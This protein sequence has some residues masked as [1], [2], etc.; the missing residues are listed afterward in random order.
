MTAQ[1]RAK[2]ERV[3]EAVRRG[4]DGEGAIGFIRESGYATTAAGIARHLRSM[5][6]RGKVLEFI[7]QGLSNAQVLL[8]CFPDAD[9]SA[10]PKEPPSQGELFGF[11]RS[12]V[13]LVD[14]D[15]ADSPVY[16]TTKISVRL[17]ND[18]C[19]AIRLAAKAEGTT[20]SQ[21]ITEILTTAL[22]RSPEMFPR[23][24]ESA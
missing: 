18:L 12:T 16:D 23:E 24:P 17:P 13:R 6:G 22:S 3:I 4:L 21:L 19:E 1:L 8:R 7:E 20:Q 2:Q 9:L 11:D 5:G 10:L 14:L 15:T